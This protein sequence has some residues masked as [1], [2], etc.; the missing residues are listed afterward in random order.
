MI[1]DPRDPD[2]VQPDMC[3]GVP[4]R[5]DRKRLAEAVAAN[6]AR[7]VEINRG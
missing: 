4:G 3:T 2:A 1:S 7:V 5:F 6:G